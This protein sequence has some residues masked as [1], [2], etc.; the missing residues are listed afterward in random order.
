MIAFA[1]FF[2]FMKIALLT[3]FGTR[4]YFVGAMKGVILSLDGGADVVDITHNI[5]PQDIRAAAFTLKACY[6]DFPD[7][8]IFVAVVDPGVGSDRRAILVET[9]DRYF[10]APDNGLLSLVL[11]DGFEF[12]AFELTNEKYFKHPVSKTF[13]GRDIFAPVAAHLLRGIAPKEFGGEIED[14]VRLENIQTKKISDS[15]IDGEIIHIDRFGNLITNFQRNCLPESFTVEIGNRIINKT[16]ENFS[17]IEIGGLGM[18]FGSAGYLE[19]ISF[20][21]SAQRI[22]GSEVS[23]KVIANGKKRSVSSGKI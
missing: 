6:L 16:V 5:P 23:E 13:H 21:D 4:D 1:D 2:V 14:I 10:I 22:L 7:K 11:S 9:E 8:T 17:D 19:I 12:H 3:D 18:I 15:R 20:K